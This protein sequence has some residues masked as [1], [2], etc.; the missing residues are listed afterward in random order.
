MSGI[1]NY[2]TREAVRVKVKKCEGLLPPEFKKF[3]VDPQITSFEVLQSLL[4]R[5]F[6]I[7]GEFTISYLARGDDGCETYL[8]L[9]SDW[10]LDAAF[11]G[12]SEPYLQLKVD[13]KPF[14]EETARVYQGIGFLTPFTASR[15]T[16]HQQDHKIR[17]EEE[18]QKDAHLHALIS[19]L[20]DWDV[21][22]PVDISR[23]QMTGLV[24]RT[25]FT[26]TILNHM[27]KTFSMVQRALNIGENDQLLENIKPL[28]QP[29]TDSEFHNYLDNI[30]RLVRPKELR[31]SVYQ[32]G[33]EPSLRK[34][35]WKHILNV[36]PEG[37]A[38]KERIDYMQKKCKEYFRLCRTWQDMIDGGKT[39]DLMHFVT[40]MVRKDVLRTDRTHKFYAG[41]D[42]NKNVVSLFNILTTYSLNHPSVS[43]CQG[44]SDLAS[45]I[46][47]T[48]KDEAH[49]YVCFCAVMHRLKP[50]FSLDGEAMTV[51]FQHLSELLQHYDPQFYEYLQQQ[52]AD[53]L[54]FCYRWLL[55]ELKR[56]FAFDDALHMLE[57]LWS[58]LPPAP[59]KDDLPLFEEEFSPFT[60][61]PHSPRLNSRENPY[62]KVRAIRKQNSSS[63]ITGVKL[64]KEREDYPKLRYYESAGSSSLSCGCRNEQIVDYSVS[65]RTQEFNSSR[66]NIMEGEY[67]TDDSQEYLPMTTSITR[68]LR[69][70]LENLNRNLPGS[71]PSLPQSP[72]GDSEDLDSPHS[73][74]SG[75]PNSCDSCSICRRGSIGPDPEDDTHSWTSDDQFSGGDQIR[76]LDNIKKLHKSPETLD[77]N[78]DLEV[79]PV[80]C[81]TPD[82]QY[83]LELESIE[84]TPQLHLQHC[85]GEILENEESYS[86]NG[87]QCSCHLKSVIPIQLV[88]SPGPEDQHHG[89][90]SSESLPDK[91]GEEC[92]EERYTAKLNNQSEGYSSGSTMS[93]KEA[94]TQEET[95]SD[96]VGGNGFIDSGVIRPVMTNSCEE[97]LE[98]SGRMKRSKLPP[99]HELGGG[100]PFMLFLCLTLLLQ[101]SDSIMRSNMDYNELAMYFD[102][103]VRKHNVTRVLHQAR[104]MFAEYL[105]MGWHEDSWKSASNPQV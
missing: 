22:A 82:D 28:K 102:K 77:V 44:M 33:L 92:A 6:D 56:E 63:S 104:T 93:S 81:S 41:S 10:D 74:I 72:T 96:Q 76:P 18:A 98:F 53:D 1:L 64:G 100:N 73:Q 66:T 60:S 89:S 38:A 19:R 59:P 105:R 101:H 80:T 78:G 40:N 87:L 25:S 8:A 45:P 43:Y 86:N 71:R 24:D 47:V 51:K 4:A 27:E 36:Y 31:L 29:M 58:S 15:G 30:G 79:E 42:D 55:L 61:C 14:E 17:Q 37:L 2:H 50:N 62:T 13:L 52:G 7:K 5:A 97:A 75:D 83:E 34:V 49:A 95:G 26:G 88:H 11:L 20:E 90:D 103:M 32:G 84:T 16:H 67:S 21:I 46:L 12:S 3:S 39:N 91:C 35:V 9:L 94:S 23:P 68:E 69:M 99:P 85:N 48:M 54:L 65:G 57:V 70:E